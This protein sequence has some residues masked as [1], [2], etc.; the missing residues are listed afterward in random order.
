[1]PD[2]SGAL[3]GHRRGKHS[4]FSREELAWMAVRLAW[5]EN[6]GWYAV[7]KGTNHNAGE[8][9]VILVPPLHGYRD[10]TVALKALGRMRDGVLPTG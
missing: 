1:M 6:S 9:S 2:G 3:R 10:W 4:G 5:S 8:F 7:T